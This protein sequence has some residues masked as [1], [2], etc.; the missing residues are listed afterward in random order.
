M[1]TETWWVKLQKHDTKSL[2]AGDKILMPDRDMIVSYIEQLPAGQR[3]TVREMRAALAEQHDCAITCP[4]TTNIHLTELATAAMHEQDGLPL[5]RTV[6]PGATALK[7][8][9][10]PDTWIAE[11]RERESR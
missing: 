11:R 4:V 2:R 8:A 3:G 10:M 5:W 1:S 9:G 6:E 7:R